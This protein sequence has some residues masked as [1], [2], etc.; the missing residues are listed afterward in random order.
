[1]FSVGK[2][3]GTLYFRDYGGFESRNPSTFWCMKQADTIYNWKDF[4]EFQIHT[5]D[6]ENNQ[7]Q[8]TYSKQNTY[9]NVI[10]DFNFHAW[11]EVGLNDY[12][13]VCKSIDL[14]GSQPY[15]MM[16][17][18]WIGART[19]TNR[20]ILL[21]TG[22]KHPELFDFIDMNWIRTGTIKHN[23]TRYMSFPDLVK[24][25][26]ALI[27][28]EGNGYSGRLKY[29][30]WS[31][32]PVLLVDRPHKEWF[33]EYLEPWKHYIPVKRDLS[34]LVE[35]TLWVT[36]NYNES[37]QIAQNA[38]EFCSMYLTRDACY[39]QWNKIICDRA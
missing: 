16:K 26:A 29:L 8:Y 36:N 28:I 35:Q 7:S 19:H 33:Y 11:P 9:T 12:D 15:D 38:Y 25:Y 39:A 6:Y 13:T 24:Q 20:N 10:P 37:L 17:V 2:K 22:S 4:D 30:L 23:A 14:A 3:N 5:D 27:D 32:R 21:D 18:G 1:M 34:D 31:H